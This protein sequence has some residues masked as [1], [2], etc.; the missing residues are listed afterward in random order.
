MSARLIG[1]QSGSP[2][3]RR[4]ANEQM[5]LATAADYLHLQAARSEMCY[6][7]LAQLSLISPDTTQLDG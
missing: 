2:F 5:Q 3:Q 6:P 1:Q 4:C 7:Y